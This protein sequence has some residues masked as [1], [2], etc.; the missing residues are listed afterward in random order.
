M[1][2]QCCNVLIL[3]FE[4]P[5]YFKVPQK[6]QS[7]CLNY[8]SSQI[9]HQCTTGERKACTHQWGPFEAKLSEKLTC[10]WYPKGSH[11]L[12]TCSH[13]ASVASISSNVF[14]SSPLQKSPKPTELSADTFKNDFSSAVQIPWNL[15]GFPAQICNRASHVSNPWR[16]PM[17]CQLNGA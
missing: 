17:N 8:W 1:S 6:S 5:W 16:V 7:R 12:Q 2:I 15:A 11:R 3:D 14:S 9:S 4:W 13:S 10:G